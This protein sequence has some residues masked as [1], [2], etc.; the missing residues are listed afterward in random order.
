MSSIKLEHGYQHGAAWD[1]GYFRVDSSHEIYYEQYGKPDGLAGMK[2][3]E[4]RR[5]CQSDHY[6]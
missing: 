4:I 2:N 3:L 1:K 6:E 5:Q